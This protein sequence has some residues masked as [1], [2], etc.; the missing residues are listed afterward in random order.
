V[1]YDAV[2]EVARDSIRNIAESLR[3][4]HGLEE[5]LA[6]VAVGRFDLYEAMLA[7]V[8]GKKKLNKE[9]RALFWDIVAYVLV[10]Q[11]LFYKIVQ[12][13]SPKGLPELPDPH[14]LET[15]Q[16]LLLE[17]KNCFDQAGKYYSPIFA[18]NSIDVLIK[19]RDF[20]VNQA[21]ARLIFTIRRL[22]PEN[23]DVDLLGRLYHD[24]IPPTTRKRMGA[25]YTNPIAAELLA[26]IAIKKWNAIVLDP[27]CGSGTLLV[28]A[29]KRKKALFELETKKQATPSMHIQ[30]LKDQIYGI[31]AMLFASHMTATN[32]LLQMGNVIVDKINVF[33]ANSL[34][35]L[36][37]EDKNS[38][39]VPDGYFDLTIMNP[40]FTFWRRLPTDERIKLEKSFGTSSMN[41]WGYFLLAAMPKLRENGMIATVLPDDFLRGKGAANVR[42]PLFKDDSYSLRAIVKS[43]V[44]VAFS[45]SSKFR[46][47][48]VFVQK[49]KP[50]AEDRVTTV[51]VKKPV[52]ELST[53][54]IVELANN[55]ENSD[56]TKLQGDSF[57]AYDY[58]HGIVKKF[59]H[60]LHPLVAFVQPELREIW[61][62]MQEFLESSGLFITLGE[63][64][65][66][67]KVRVRIYRPG[68][69][70]Q[71]NLAPKN[72]RSKIPEIARNLFATKYKAGGKWLFRVDKEQEHKVRFSVRRSKLDFSIPRE[73]L[74]PS[75]RT[76]S[77]VKSIDITNKSEFIIKEPSSIPSEIRKI[78]FWDYDA[79]LYAEKDIKEAY[80]DLSGNYVLLMKPQIPSPN[81]FWFCYYSDK[82]LLSTNDYMLKTVGIKEE[83]GKIL[84]LFTNTTPGILQIFAL[85]PEI[86]GAWSRL[87]KESVWNY[88]YVPNPEL[89]N[90]SQTKELVSTF[91]MYSGKESAALQD[92]FRCSNSIQTAMD[93]A[94]LKT[95][96]F[97]GLIG[98]CPLVYRLFDA[99]LQNLLDVMSHHK[100]N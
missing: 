42:D 26:T 65:K 93:D 2:V 34:D 95:F 63:L 91:D 84:A 100:N 88:L 66:A 38:Q 58:P 99:E 79:T 44:E 76:Y 94:I 97:R 86:R 40:P 82:P 59:I 80:D 73:E 48:L 72:I 50:K 52:N 6:E 89:I 49:T 45:E 13:I 37:K 31:D 75:L 74:L 70:K 96:G 69:Y 16:E 62:R 3:I 36:T 23:V 33:P 90:S 29:Y 22:E 41:Y 5:S 12:K 51:L 43:K 64:E 35:E 57:Y 1:A 98:K 92:R 11:L 20:R 8:V 67:G 39:I 30:F 7:D 46:D 28:S 21:I 60:N 87:D 85:R 15:N 17:V 27:A 24:T 77:S 55:L 19:A 10:N 14:P 18:S 54:D 25:F 68:Q 9:A 56:L 61:L 83:Y 81:L 47:Y 53:N 71:Y 78:L 4:H 32:L